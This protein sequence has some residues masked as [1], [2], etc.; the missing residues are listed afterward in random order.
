MTDHYAVIGNPVA[1]SKSPAI[2]AAFARQESQVIDYKRILCDIGT[3]E[4]TIGVFRAEGG[5]GVNVTVPFKHQAFELA[6]RRSERAE[7]AGAVNTLTFN[8][9]G[10]AGDNT[11]GVGLVRDIM[12]NLNFE[13]HDKRVL[14]LGAGG[15]SFGVVGPLLAQA[16]SHLTIA[17]RTVSKALDLR[18]R[19]ISH[20]NVEGCSYNALTGRRFDLVINATSAGLAGAMPSLP[21]NI[22]AKRALAYDM[23]YGK[24]TPFMQFAQAC[25]ARVADGLG[26]LVEQA[27]ESFLI[28]RG[29]RPVTAPVMEMLRRETEST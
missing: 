19:F 15:A 16:L 24:T 25:G 26:M 12:Q 1:H 2:H 10:V 14:L 8:E 22:F 11:D 29:V 3:F 5:K 6:T 9:Q 7:Q 21:G 17:N 23:V 27:A 18:S 4:Q 13:L 20:V 28:W